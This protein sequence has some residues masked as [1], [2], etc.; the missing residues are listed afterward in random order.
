MY[1]L[2]NKGADQLHRYRKAD[3]HLCFCICRLLVFSRG[4]SNVKHK[5]ESHRII[6]CTKKMF[7]LNKELET[8]FKFSGIMNSINLQRQQLSW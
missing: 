4:I 5:T 1:Y 6:D 2:R 7:S 3:L 8:E